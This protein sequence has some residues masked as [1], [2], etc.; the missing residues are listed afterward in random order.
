MNGPHCRCDAALALA[1]AAQDVLETGLEGQ[2]TAIQHLSDSLQVFGM[3]YAMQVDCCPLGMDR[4]AGQCLRLK[5][6]PP[7]KMESASRFSEALS[8]ITPGACNPS[9]IALAIAHACRQAR[10]EGAVPSS[11]A[12]VRLMAGQLAWICQ[13]DAF[14]SELPDLIM[15]CQRRIDNAAKDSTPLKH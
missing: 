3:A 6:L 8:L 9:A 1:D 2:Q 13:A 12:A 7:E 15:E 5:D 4:R 10:S 11:D 14:F